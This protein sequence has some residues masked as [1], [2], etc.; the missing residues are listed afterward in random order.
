MNIITGYCGTPHVT[1]Q[2]DRDVNKGIIGESSYILPVGSQLEATITGASEVT[3][4]DG[5]LMLQGCTASIGYGESDVLTLEAGT[6]GM[7]RNDLI[8]AQYTKN[9][10]G[11]EALELVVKTGT[12]T[13][14]TPADPSYTD[15]DIAAGDTLVEFPLYRVYING[16]SA[17]TVT[18]LASVTTPMASLA[19]AIKAG[20][21]WTSLGQYTGTI[22]SGY[23]TLP[24]GA[25]EVLVCV[26]YSNNI[27]VNLQSPITTDIFT[28]AGGALVN[29]YGST[30][31]GYV[32]VMCYYLGSST[33]GVKLDTAYNGTTDQTA[34]TTWSVFYR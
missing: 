2:Q 18:A 24:S 8:V 3:V 19:S 32:K 22:P 5:V 15:G 25:V 1:A 4:T 13:T 30:F 21:A 6:A 14:G 34:T 7:K 23:V 12:A 28:P 33:Y 27:S 20:L 26:F 9:T 16:V 29:I 10:S 11:V 31:D 17:S